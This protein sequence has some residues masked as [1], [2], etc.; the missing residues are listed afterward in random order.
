MLAQFYGYDSHSS[1]MAF[2]PALGTIWYYVVPALGK[3]ISH[4]PELFR[5]RSTRPDPVGVQRSSQSQ[6]FRPGENPGMPVWVGR[7]G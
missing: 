3:E 7:S 1:W 6:F 5:C 2:I 4:V